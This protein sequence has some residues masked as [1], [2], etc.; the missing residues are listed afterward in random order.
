MMMSAL[1]R[2]FSFNPALLGLS[3]DQDGI[4][5]IRKSFLVLGRATV[6]PFPFP[7]CH[8]NGPG[9]DDNGSISYHY[10][11]GQMIPNPYPLAQGN[12][13]CGTMCSSNACVKVQLVT[14]Q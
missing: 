4:F 11:A 8:Y 14:F 2:N 7:P 3:R 5:R 6:D 9:D 12:S 10:K 1:H 13:I